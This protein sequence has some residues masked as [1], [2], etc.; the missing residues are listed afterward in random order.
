MAA[1]KTI[2][3]DV[4]VNEQVWRSQPPAKTKKDEAYFIC[5]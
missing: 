2:E 3:G 4:M 1:T 5:W